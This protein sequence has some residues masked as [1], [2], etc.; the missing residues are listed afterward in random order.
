M[1][2]LNHE[3]SKNVEAAFNRTLQQQLGTESWDQFSTCIDG[4][5][6]RMHPTP[7]TQIE[8]G[9]VTCEVMVLDENFDDWKAKLDGF[10]FLTIAIVQSKPLSIRCEV[11]ILR[12]EPGTLA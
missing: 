5:A 10:R 7:Q 4:F 12:S 11:R 1:T 9:S 6:T 3:L 2:T 8:D